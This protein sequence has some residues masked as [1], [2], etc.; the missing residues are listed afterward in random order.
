MRKADEILTNA[1]DLLGTAKAGVDML[2]ATD[3][4]QRKLGIRNLAVFGRAITNVLQ[5][6]RSFSSDFDSW[7]E[8][9]VERMKNDPIVSH[10]YKIRSEI[11]KEG[12]LSTNVST[13]LRSFNPVALMA[14][15]PKPPGATSFFIGDTNGGSGWE[16]PSSTGEILNF[17]VDLPKDLPGIDIEV[18]MHFADASPEIEAANIVDLSDHYYEELRQICEDAKHK[19][20]NS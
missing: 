2:H 18:S 9:W 1:F 6:L 17:Y 12:K 4:S 15:V 10:F 11:L 8:P 13:Q 5:Q 19:F 16:V 3:P 14:V 7:Y 20:K